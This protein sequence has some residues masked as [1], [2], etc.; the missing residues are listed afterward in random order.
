MQSHRVI[1]PDDVPVDGVD[2]VVCYPHEG[3]HGRVQRV[4]QVVREHLNH[5]GLCG[6]V[7]NVHESGTVRRDEDAVTGDELHLLPE[8][9]SSILVHQPEMMQAE[10]EREREGERQ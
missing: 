8:A 4:V 10:R 3:G 6:H 7:Q 9:T 1:R 5:S 2:G